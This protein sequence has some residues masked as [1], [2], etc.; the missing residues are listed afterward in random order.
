MMLKEAI[1][2]NGSMDADKIV[3]YIEKTTF[4]GTAAT[5]TFDKRH[6][7]VWEPGKTTGIGV[8]WQNGEKVPFWPPAIKG[9]KPFKFP[10]G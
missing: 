7:L 2:H 10:G 9:M 1:E 4:V 5:D 8:Q 3:A 6:D